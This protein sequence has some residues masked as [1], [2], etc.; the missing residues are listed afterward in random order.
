MADVRDSKSRAPRGVWVRPPPP[1]N[2]NPTDHRSGFFFNGVAMLNP[3]S[4]TLF[5]F[6]EQCAMGVVE[7]N[8]T[9]SLLPMSFSVLELELARSDLSQF[10]TIY[11]M[12]RKANFVRIT[13]LP[14][15]VH[16]ENDLKVPGTSLVV[17]FHDNKDALNSDNWDSPLAAAVI[18]IDEQSNNK[19]V[20]DL[21]R[22]NE[23]IIRMESLGLSINLDTNIS[24]LMLLD[25]EAIGESIVEKPQ[26]KVGNFI[27]VPVY[28]AEF[29]PRLT[30]AIEP[31]MHALN[32]VRSSKPTLMGEDSV[33]LSGILPD[34]IA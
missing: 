31:L 24:I 19:D 33:D 32:H 20:E 27:F 9:D 7:G 2:N 25:L 28:Y 12:I 8:L 16:K 5:I 34:A 4:E 30:D 3:D 11:Q 26:M 21:H 29:Q 15:P 1:A 23:N 17:S 13:V 6:P 18:S 10:E 14:Q 22:F